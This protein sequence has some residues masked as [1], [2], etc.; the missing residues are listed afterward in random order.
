M[1]KYLDDNLEISVVRCPAGLYLIKNF[2]VLQNPVANKE[3]A[4]SFLDSWAT[5]KKL[6]AKDDLDV[7]MYNKAYKEGCSYCIRCCDGK[8]MRCH[9]ADGKRQ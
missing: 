1:K 4:Q 5:K 6:Q 7:D 3:V 2:G 8:C 9:D